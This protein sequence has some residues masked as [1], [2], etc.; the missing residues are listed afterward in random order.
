ML[1]YTNSNRTVSVSTIVPGR[2]CEIEFI[3]Y[4]MLWEVVNSGAVV[5]MPFPNT[6]TGNADSQGKSKD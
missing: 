6:I 2:L 5:L 1:R 3:V 4:L